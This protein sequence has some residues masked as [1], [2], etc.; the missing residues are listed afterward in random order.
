MLPNFIVIGGQKAGSTWVAEVLA[1]HPDVFMYHTEIPFFEDPDYTRLTLRDLEKFFVHAGGKSAVGMKRPNLLTR[2]ECP[3]RI[4]HDLPGVKLIAMLRNPVERAVSSYFHLMRSGLLP[5]ESMEVGMRRVL[6]GAYDAS[7]PAGR[8]RMMGYGFYHAG[9]QRYL[10]HVP[11][12]RMLIV[13]YDRVRSGASE[14]FREMCRF[15]GVR[16][17]DQPAALEKR[18]MEGNYSIARQRIMAPLLTLHRRVTPDKLRTHERRGLLAAAAR[19]AVHGV[20]RFVLSRLFAAKRPMP[21]VELQQRLIELYREDVTALGMFLGED[22]SHWLL[23]K[24]P[25][26]S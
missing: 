8:E 25:K 18:V 11:R 17:L 10:Q 5:I 16:E 19:T 21:S 13:L 2:A 23:V 26:P 14:L 22:L 12:E 6:D 1:H 24:E 20:D 4:A 15:L 7:W 9:I 3:A